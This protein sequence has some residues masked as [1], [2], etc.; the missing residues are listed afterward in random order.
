MSPPAGPRRLKTAKPVLLTTYQRERSDSEQSVIV[1][2]PRQLSIPPVP[3]TPPPPPPS[4]VLDSSSNR[5]ET[6][7]KRS[8]SNMVDVNL[9]RSTTMRSAIRQPLPVPNYN[10]HPTFCLP[11]GNIS[12]LV[13]NTLFTIHRYFIERDSPAFRDMFSLGPPP[14]SSTTEGSVENPIVLHGMSRRDFECFCSILYPPRFNKEPFHASEDWAAVLR[15]ADKYE[16]SDIRQMAIEKLLAIGSCLDRITIG[17]QFQVQ[18]LLLSGYRD[19]CNRSD[20]LSA[21]EIASL[22]ATDVALIVSMRERLGVGCCR[23]HYRD[24]NS[25]KL[26]TDNDIAAWFVDHLPMH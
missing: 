22:P 21:E 20:F 2:S 5:P 16:F 7:M 24:S 26:A 19:I 9:N 4:L 6:Q 1:Q 11:D 18:S 14:G 13:E 3:Q 23:L 25:P 8:S 12:F 10:R 17:R 15:V